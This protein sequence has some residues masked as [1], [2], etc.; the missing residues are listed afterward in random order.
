MMYFLTPPKPKDTEPD[1]EEYPKSCGS[2]SALASASAFADLGILSSGSARGLDNVVP[3]K[4]HSNTWGM[5]GDI[6]ICILS[7]V[8]K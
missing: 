2:A 1:G 6:K 3:N 4:A 7:R 8:S 5:D